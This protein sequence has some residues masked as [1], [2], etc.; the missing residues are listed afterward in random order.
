[1]SKKSNRIIIFG[2]SGFISSNLYIFFK[3]KGLNVI[4]LSRNGYDLTKKSSIQKISSKIKNN[5]ILIFTSYDKS[6]KIYQNILMIELVLEAIK[7][8]VI[9][10]FIYLS[11]VAVYD[12]D[13][14]PIDE[15]ST[16]NP[17]SSYGAMH[18]QREF[19]LKDYF[20]KKN[21]K[22]L[23]LR[24]TNVFGFGHHNYG[25]ALF[26]K[27]AIKGKEIIIYGNGEE[28]RSHVYIN[29]LTSIIE[30]LIKSKSS[31][32]YNIASKKSYSFLHIASIIKKIL[33]GD[34]VIKTVKRNIPVYRKP[35]KWTQIFRYIYNLGKPITNIY[36]TKFN[37]NK[38]N[39]IIKKH[40]DNLEENL[41]DLV[42]I[43][44]KS[45][46]K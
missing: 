42:K 6:K 20:H 37:T 10:K 22:L 16:C 44:E 15:E 33:G 40:D 45:K 39:K 18:L 9:K 43:Y 41:I 14:M 38:L 8:K 21:N 12:I 31:G 3:K 28:K 11:S 23:I 25:P 4:S 2:S 13:K 34:I 32:I 46:T 26:I 5:D 29:D 1:M 35:Y 17:Y 24:L 19:I 27:S 36:H 7:D 30:N